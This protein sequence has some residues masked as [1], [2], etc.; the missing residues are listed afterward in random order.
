MKLL[1]LEARKSEVGYLG[2]TPLR[3]EVRTCG[4]VGRRGM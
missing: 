3:N 2:S 4:K 1:W